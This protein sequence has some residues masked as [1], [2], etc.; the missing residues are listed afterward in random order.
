MEIFP[1]V[2]ALIAAVLYGAAFLT[3]HKVRANWYMSPALF[4]WASR[5]LNVIAYIL[6]GL[7]TFLILLDVLLGLSLTVVYFYWL[8]T[9]T[10]PAQ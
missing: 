6:F 10:Q 3:W 8:L 1:P 7:A 5:I 4:N 9:P 2:I